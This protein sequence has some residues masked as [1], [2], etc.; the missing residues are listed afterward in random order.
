MNK[1]DQKHS[2]ET[3]RILKSQGYADN[4]LLYAAL[5]H[6]IGKGR[7]AGARVRLW[8][9]VAYVVLAAGAPSLLRRMTSGRNSLA[10]LYHHAERGAVVAEAQGLSPAAVELIR[11]HHDE[12]HE[13]EL[14]A[15]LRAADD[16]C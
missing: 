6:D 8:H 16:A 7:L 5:L 1:R 11:R 10:S 4:D 15:L 12:D 14:L 9:R 2:I 3:F 13:D